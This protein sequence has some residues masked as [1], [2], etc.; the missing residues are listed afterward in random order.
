MAA[1]PLGNKYSN[2]GRGCVAVNL[3]HVVASV[4]PML[5]RVLA[6]GAMKEFQVGINLSFD[7]VS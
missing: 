2:A 6:F 4:L 7:R 5:A 3:Q 1:H